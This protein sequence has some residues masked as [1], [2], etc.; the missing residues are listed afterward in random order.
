MAQKQLRPKVVTVALI[1]MTVLVI[2]GTRNLVLADI[3]TTDQLAY[4]V[5]NYGSELNHDVV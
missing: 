1:L 5:Y 2:G 4:Y 3:S